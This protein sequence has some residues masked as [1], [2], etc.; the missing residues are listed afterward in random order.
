MGINW[1]L[2]TGD[3]WVLAGLELGEPGVE[4]VPAVGGV[5]EGE[6]VACGGNGLKGDGCLGFLGQESG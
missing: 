3:R 1:L 2:M 5:A 6:G 4:V